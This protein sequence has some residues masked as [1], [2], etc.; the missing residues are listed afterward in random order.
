MHFGLSKHIKYIAIILMLFSSSCID[1]DQHLPEFASPLQGDNVVIGSQ[2]YAKV[3]VADPQNVNEI[4]YLLDGKLLKKVK[5]LDSVSISTH[6]LRLGYR[7]IT[8]IVGRNSVLDTININIVLS[9]NK[10][11]VQLKYE[12]INSFP[13][14]TT[15]YTQG[16][17]YIDGRLLESTGLKG[18][19][20]LKYVDLRSGK[21]LHKIKLPSAY[22]GEGSVKVG[23]KIIMLTWQENLGLVFDAKTLKQVTTFPYE[24]SREGWGLT[25]DGKQILRSDGSNRIWFMNAKTY[26]EEDFLEVYDANGA[27]NSLNELEYINGKIFANVYQT[28]KV[29]QINAQSGAVEAEIDLSALV[30]KN[31]FKTTDEQQDNVLNGIAW[32][33]KEKRLFVTGKKWPKL[34]EIKLIK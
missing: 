32:D 6:N 27:V 2:F 20:E 3:K 9:V 12:V 5:G 31:F 11:S 23:N 21:D 14:Q 17:S 7:I 1:K 18:E 13:H 22:F 16:L 30:P 19:S 15:A 29:L 33:E 34:Y 10:P 4:T 25:F 8:A 24:K 26:K 28:S